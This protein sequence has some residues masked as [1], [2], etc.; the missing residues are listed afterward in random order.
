VGGGMI[1][2]SP[3]GSC[4]KP[5][6][7]GVQALSMNSLRSAWTPVLAGLKPFHYADEGKIRSS[8]DRVIL[9]IG[10][11]QNTGQVIIDRV[12]VSLPNE[13]SVVGMNSLKCHFYRWLSRSIIL[14]DL[15]GPVRPVDL[16]ARNIPPETARLAH[17]LAL[18]QESFAAL[19]FGI[20]P[21][22]LQ[23]NRGLRSR[24]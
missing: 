16:S 14:K 2:P 23:R 6:A 24:I 13:I 15:V 9:S 22:I 19:Q 17:P 21:D 1:F 11:V 3:A 10:L 5:A 8:A 12:F 20:K 7:A 4:L 18:S